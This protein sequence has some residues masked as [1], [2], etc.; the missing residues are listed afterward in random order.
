MAAATTTDNAV[1]VQQPDGRM[2]LASAHVQTTNVPPA[3]PKPVPD[4]V[5]VNISVE[6]VGAMLGRPV[7]KAHLPEAPT[8]TELGNWEQEA[9]SLDVNAATSLGFSVGNLSV[10][11]HR[12]A[13]MFGVSRWKD[14]AKDG[15]AYRFGVA[16]RAIIVV[17]STKVTGDL[18]LPILAARVELGDALA[19]AHLLVR[20]YKGPGVA[21]H[22]PSWQTF[23]VDS[24]GEYMRSVAQIQKLI[25]KDDKN[26]VPELLAT[27]LVSLPQPRRTPSA[28]AVG[29]VYALRAIADG[30][31]LTE[32]IH[33]LPTMDQDVLAQVRAVYGELLNG[34]EL[35]RPDDEQRRIAREQLFG[36]DFHPILGR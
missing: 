15:A 24:Y 12:Q 32:A 27:S 30:R 36:L 28:A 31:P 11:Y 6:D 19:T 26:V 4:L 35:A 22:L 23:G 3:T 17:S 18:T 29:C 25:T 20:G 34:R 21:D 5:P 14:V 13:L 16:L 1:H 2:A 10:G 9:Y 7:D 8:A 33:R